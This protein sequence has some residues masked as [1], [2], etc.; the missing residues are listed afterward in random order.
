[1]NKFQILIIIAV[2]LFLLMYAGNSY[3]NYS[4]YDKIDKKLERLDTNLGAVNRNT[5]GLKT[6]LFDISWGIERLR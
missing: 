1:M 2:G 4:Y 6:Y 5:N 3:V